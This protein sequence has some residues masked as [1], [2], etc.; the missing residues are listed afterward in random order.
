MYKALGQTSGTEKF[1]VSNATALF[2][3]ITY[4]RYST[5]KMTIGIDGQGR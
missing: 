1:K 5:S 3:L 2:N 4:V